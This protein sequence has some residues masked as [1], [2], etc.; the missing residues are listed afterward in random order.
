MQLRRL[1]YVVRGRKLVTKFE[2]RGH[3][4]ATAISLNWTIS[5]M[6]SRVVKQITG[7]LGQNHA[8]RL[9]AQPAARSGAR[10][11]ARRNQSVARPLGTTNSPALKFTADKHYHGADQI[12]LPEST[13]GD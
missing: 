12:S 11:L 7:S 2:I 1:Y 3:W 10:Q 4:K 6:Y 9:A 5:H 13:A 8:L